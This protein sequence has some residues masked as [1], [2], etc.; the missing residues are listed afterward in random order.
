MQVQSKQQNK[1]KKQA[2][3]PGKWDHVKPSPHQTAPYNARVEQVVRAFVDGEFRLPSMDLDATHTGNITAYANFQDQVWDYNGT[4]A[5]A[6]GMYSVL[7]DEAVLH[8][9]QVTACALLGVRARDI[10]KLLV[11]ATVGDDPVLALGPEFG[12]HSPLCEYKRPVVCSID[13]VYAVARAIL[14]GTDAKS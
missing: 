12:G 13:A 10:L 11:T 1:G 4:G 14:G 2:K 6:V 5:V 3:V 7:H 8:S 9:N